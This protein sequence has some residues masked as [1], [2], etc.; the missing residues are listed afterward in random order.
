MFYNIDTMCQ[1][2]KAFFI[3]IYTF[4]NLTSAKMIRKF[5]KGGVIYGKKSFITLTPCANIVKLFS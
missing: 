3:I 5:T 4:L 2:Y 1:D